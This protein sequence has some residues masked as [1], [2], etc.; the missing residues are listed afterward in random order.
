MIFASAL[1]LDREPLTWADLP[2]A[3]LLWVQNTGAV[4]AFGLAIW[5]LAQTLRRRSILGTPGVRPASASGTLST[6]FVVGTLLCV[7]GY[8]LVLFMGVG[9]MLGLGF[10]GGWLPSGSLHTRTVG[11]NVLSASGAL[12]LTL[13]L[14]PMLY[15]L[16]RGLRWER[17]WALARLSL[18]EA[19]RKRVVAI[20]FAIA[21]V[22]LFAD[23][24]ITYKPE[25]Q[26]R[27]Y[28]RVVYWSMA[29]LFL[30]TAALLG[31]FSIPADIKNQSIHTIV[32]KP[33]EKF[34]IVLGRFLGFALLLT[35]C[36]A[37][38]AVLSLGYLL[39]GVNDEAAR[40]SGTA[41][42]PVFG[43][44]SFIG[45]KS[46][47]RADSVGREWDY[48]QYISGPSKSNPDAKRQYAVW[49]YAELPSGLGDA[50]SPIRFEYTFDVFRLSKGKE[51]EDIP[52][53][54]TFV[55]G[56]VP[57][58]D[59]EARLREIGRERDKR[60]QAAR[61]DYDRAKSRAKSQEAFKQAE[62]AFTRRR[63]EIEAELMREYRVYQQS[64]VPVTDYHT[65]FVQVP[66][67]FFAAL[68]QGAAPPPGEGRTAPPALRALVGVDYGAESQMLGVAPRDFYLLAAEGFF[69]V[70]FLKGVI[71]MWCT[72]M[73]VLGVALSCS[74]YL[75]G[76]IS[77]LATLVILGFGM[78]TE[79]LQQVA[80]RRVTGG[81]VFEAVYR[82]STRTNPNAH[83]ADSPTTSILRLGD[84][85]FSWWIGRIINLLPDIN[86]HD[87][88]PY[89][90]NGFDIA[91]G[92]VLL[93]DNLLPLIGYLLPWFVLAYF[94]LRYRE[95]AN[96]T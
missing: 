4:A 17:V 67:A 53:T 9:F 10:L 6:V 40:E 87:L 15:N 18:K 93:V 30:I 80:L 49:S 74:T 51:N 62:E 25:D 13:V 94:L 69:W 79:F 50:T 39:R 29:P 59:V 27:N 35:A 61:Q 83:L 16:A 85:F 44:L 23:W 8:L 57:T 71:G 32:T 20:F 90:A 75:S 37:I 54:F 31:S 38:V 72:T 24:F 58:D 86:R 81:G 91:W 52:C 26:L 88:H 33:V 95:I 48:R 56:S 84:E 2:G 43:Q 11:D 66:A 14:A 73:L 76:V 19:I 82:L 3:I 60:Q 65:Q 68:Q 36:Q 47:N 34:E 63:A 12:A 28:V 70:N 1:V 64:G 89:V 21:L 96:P 92:Q 5:T 55:D 77:L 42:V 45:T 46:A 7:G 22:F 41:R 78:W